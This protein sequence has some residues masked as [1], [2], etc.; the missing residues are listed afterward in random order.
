MV[1]LAM[2]SIDAHKGSA[3]GGFGIALDVFRHAKIHIHAIHDDAMRLVLPRAI[4]HR[5]IPRAG[6]A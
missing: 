6:C 5:D 2:H 4:D 1:V 3:I